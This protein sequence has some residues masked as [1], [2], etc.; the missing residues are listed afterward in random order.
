MLGGASPS[1]SLKPHATLGQDSKKSTLKSTQNDLMSVK[2]RL[3]HQRKYEV[4][5]GFN[6]TKRLIMG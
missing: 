5:L 4:G 1:P 3:N 6:G 2:N